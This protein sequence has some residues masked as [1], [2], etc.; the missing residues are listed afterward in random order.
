MTSP[1]P[2]APATDVATRRQHFEQELLPHLDVLYS[3]ALRLTRTPAD[4]EDLVQD[5]CLRAYR[6]FDNFSAGTNFRAWLLRILTNT[7]INKYRRSHIERAAVEGPRGN[8][9]GAGVMSRATM[10]ALSQPMEEA[11]RRL[12]CAEVQQVLDGL[13]HEHRLMVLLADVEELS[14]REIAEVVGCPI[15]TVMS[16]LHR[17]RTQVRTQL[18]AQAHALGILTSE[19]EPEAEQ[20][21]SL[22]AYRKRREA[23]W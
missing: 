6:F 13:P 20:P 23:G 3:L 14:Y 22:S 9:V 8:D 4:A 11:E 19:P 21:L 12:L 5:A 10:R 16:R 2:D 1:T 7:F 17:A 18:V 15:G